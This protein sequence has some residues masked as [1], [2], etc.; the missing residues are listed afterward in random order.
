MIIT[1]INKNNST[2]L[3]KIKFKIYIFQ[4]IS[5]AYYSLISFLYIIYCYYITDFAKVLKFTNI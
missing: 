5:N 1:I 2:N 3:R 4:E